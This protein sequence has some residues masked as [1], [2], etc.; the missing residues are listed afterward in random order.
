MQKD[1]HYFCKLY[2]I[3][4]GPES[5]NRREENVAANLMADLLPAPGRPMKIIPRKLHPTAQLKPIGIFNNKINAKL[6]YIDLLKFMI[7]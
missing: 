5:I 4:P 6:I 2:L 7:L 3:L 1:I